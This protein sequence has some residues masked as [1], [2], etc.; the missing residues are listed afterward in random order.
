MIKRENCTLKHKTTRH[1]KAE[2]AARDRIQKSGIH[3]LKT[4]GL[5]CFTMAKVAEHAEIAKGSLYRHFSS[6]EELLLS[7]LDC[8]YEPLNQ[9]IFDIYE[10]DIEPLEKIRQYLIA[11]FKHCEYAPELF[12]ELHGAF[13]QL[14][15]ID[16]KTRRST[17]WDVIRVIIKTLEDGIQSNQFRPLNAE[18][19]AYYLTDAT[20]GSIVRRILTRCTHS[21]EEEIRE[22]FALVENGISK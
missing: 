7:I 3:I 11:S 22:I 12:C 21:P 9:I 15:E 8:Y 2:K 17:Y 5:K 14:T 10:K 19:T 20:E 1:E 13:G 4:I 6:K 16:L 18:L